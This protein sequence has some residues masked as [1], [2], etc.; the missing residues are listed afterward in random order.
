MEPSLE[1][2]LKN[3]EQDKDADGNLEKEELRMEDILKEYQRV[4]TLGWGLE[5]G[6]VR[7]SGRGTGRRT[8]VLGARHRS[9]LES[10][11][12]VRP[13]EDTGSPDDGYWVGEGPDRTRTHIHV[14]AHLGSTPRLAQSTV[15]DVN[16]ERIKTPSERFDD[17]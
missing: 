6:V 15:H 9:G 10:D 11:G 17:E 5:V 8:S 12:C 4:V 16:N 7:G 13:D 3:G 14:L 2:T 1:V